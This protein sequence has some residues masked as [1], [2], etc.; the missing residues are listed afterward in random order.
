V[1]LRCRGTATRY[2]LSSNAKLNNEAKRQQRSTKSFFSING[3]VKKCLPSAI[4]IRCWTNS[5]QTG[6]NVE[7]NS[8]Y[9]AISELP[10]HSASSPRTVTKLK[11]HLHTLAN[12]IVQLLSI[13]YVFKV[14]AQK[15]VMIVRLANK[16]T[17]VCKKK[18]L[19]CVEI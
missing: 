17:F 12:D 8:S 13:R 2:C 7:G 6:L 15:Y 3:S 1:C 18:P 16:A 9:L 4:Q 19:Q 14:L 10:W 5:F 11:L